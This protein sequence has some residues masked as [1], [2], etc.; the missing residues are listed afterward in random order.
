MR[1][2]EVPCLYDIQKT[3]ADNLKEGPR[4]S[5]TIPERSFPPED[6]W[7]D[8][9]GHKVASPLGVPAG[10]LLNSR[11]IECAANLGFDIPAYK[12]IRSSS[13]P[14]HPL[15]N[16]VFIDPHFD[17][18]V[19]IQLDNPSSLESL[20]LTNSFGMPSKDPDYLIKDIAKA[21]SCL[22]KGQ[23]MIVSVVGSNQPGISFFD[24]FVQVALLAK[25][26][27]AKII[28]ANFSC[29]NVDAKAGELYTDPTTVFEL[30]SKLVKA[31][32]PIPLIIKVGPFL[33]ADLM[34]A[35]LLSAAKAGIRGFCGLNAISMTVQDKEGRSPFGPQRTKSGIC[36]APIRS[37][38][39]EF[40]TR[41][42][43]IIDRLKLELCLLGV[44][45]IT[46]PDHFRAFLKAGADIVMSA[47]GMM[48]DP[49][50]GL[51]YHHLEYKNHEKARS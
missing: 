8:F 46:K 34:Q 32:H 16:M 9:L 29:P 2:P 30:G 26:G 28:E 42:R 43:D 5:E 31:I 20:G 39:L 41:A 7:I 12:T 18:N 37:H 6:Q 33:H 51:K 25:Q 10:P 36:G 40:I 17:K 14:G 4:F 49:Y 21:N 11:W 1:Y 45:G 3:W 50:L 23:V 47:T 15:P 48:W 27:G 38:A 19:A 13:H 22:K 24:D 44:G 35:V